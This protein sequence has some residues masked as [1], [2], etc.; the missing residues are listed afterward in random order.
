MPQVLKVLQFSEY[1]M[2]VY[3]RVTQIKSELSLNMA[4]YVSIMPEYI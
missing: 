4:Q 3:E 1:I 2:V